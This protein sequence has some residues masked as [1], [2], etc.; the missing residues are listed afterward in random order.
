MGSNPGNLPPVQVPAGHY[1]VGD[2]DQ[3]GRLTAWQVD[4]RGML[5]R[6][7]PDRRWEP[8]CPKFAEVE[9][10]EERWEAR[11]EWYRAVYF[12]WKRQVIAAIEADPA[13]AR[14]AFARAYPQALA[15][16]AAAQARR[17]W[18]AEER[19]ARRVAEELRAAAYAAT[20]MSTNRIALELGAISWSTARAR[21]EAGRL[22]WAAD[23]AGSRAALVAWYQRLRLDIDVEALVDRLVAP[24]LAAVASAAVAS[25][26]P[27]VMAGRKSGASMT[28]P[29]ESR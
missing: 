24:V 17:T 14:A 15:D 4:G 25:Q 6:H 18:E 5:H 12:V 10:R 13:A 16:H 28:D 1:A 23:P 3:P 7:P 2:P 19:R 9:D 22:A 8:P 27:A 20:G 26:V 21:I 29:P 11:A